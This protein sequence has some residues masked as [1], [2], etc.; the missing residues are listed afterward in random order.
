MS[1]AIF[2]SAGVPDP[3]RGPNYAA[4]AD[5]VAINAAIAALVHVALGRRQL[6]FGGHPA[7]TP[8]IWV[9]AEEMGVDYGAWVKLYQTLFFK[10]E[11]PED[12]QRFQNVVYTPAEADREASLLRMRRQMLGNFQFEA[13]VFVG[14]MKG[15]EEE[16]ELFKSMHPKASLLP[17]AS[18]GGAALVVHQAMGGDQE[19]M[20]DLDYITLLHRR[21]CVHVWENRYA[22]PAL[23]P[24][25]MEARR[26]RPPS[27]D[28]SET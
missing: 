3:I 14:G 2:L 25:E 9:V 10:D 5:V 8:M 22:T 16:Y 7:I 20:T 28:K 12:N 17:L 24:A 21:L 6:V 11:F 13:G 19:L 23:Q 1:G 15:V 18:T 26:W 4:T 27:P